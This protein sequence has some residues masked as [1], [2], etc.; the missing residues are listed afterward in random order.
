MKLIRILFCIIVFIILFILSYC[1][2]PFIAWIFGA[3]FLIIV[4]AP[5]YAVVATI[6]LLFLVGFVMSEVFDE[7]YYLKD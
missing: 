2:I 6:F 4:Q 3:S 5:E 1:I 7:D